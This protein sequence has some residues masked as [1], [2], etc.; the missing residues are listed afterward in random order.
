ME[1]ENRQP[2]LG[3]LV[4]TAAE[5]MEG[6]RTI[7]HPYEPE[8]VE[9]LQTAAAGKIR[10]VA[11]PWYRGRMA[12]AAGVLLVAL[13]ALALFV[14]RMPAGGVAVA[15]VA[16]PWA[17][18]TYTHV[19]VRPGNTEVAVG[20]SLNVVAVFHG[21]LPHDASLRWRTAQ[22]DYWQTIP[23]SPAANG[24]CTNLM[25]NLTNAIVYQV[26]G[27]GA[28]SPEYSVNTFTPPEIKS[29]TTRVEFPAYTKHPAVEQT[30]P[31]LRVVRGSHLAF[32][33][34]VAGD[35]ASA[36]LC[37]S[38]QPPIEL[39]RDADNRW[40]ANLAKP[41]S[42]DY[43]LELIDT[44]GRTGGN[45][46]PYHLVVVPDEPPLV[47]IVDP[48]ADVRA[49]PTDKVPLRVTA[50]DDFAVTGI[51]V[52]YHKLGQPEQSLTCLAT[53]LDEAS[54]GA[55]AAID[56]TPLHLQPYELVA[57]HAEARD[58]NTLDG[59]GTGKSPVYFIEFTTNSEVV[60]S[61]GGGGGG[62]GQKINLLE[63]EKQII[64]ATTAV[65]EEKLREKLPDVASVQRQTQEYAQTFRDNSP[66][67][68]AAP[69]EAR[70]EFDAALKSMGG[71]IIALN[72]VQ[73]EPSLTSEEDALEHLYQAVKYFPELKPCMCNCTGIKIVAQAIEKKKQEDKQQQK[74]E[75]PKLIA[76]AKKAAAAQAQLNGL[77]RR[78]AEEANPSLAKKE[79][80]KPGSKPGSG[81]NGP[82]GENPPPADNPDAPEPPKAD[83]PE[84]Q[85]MAANPSVAQ[86][87]L[88]EQ[89]SEMAAKLRELAGNN[90]QISGPA[91][92]THE[93]RGRKYAEGRKARRW[94]QHARGGQH[95]Q[96]RPIRNRRYHRIAGNP[97]ERPAARLG[98]RRRGISPRVRRQDRRLS[99]RP[100]VSTM[101][102]HRSEH[103]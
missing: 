17:N 76:Q 75:L 33:V 37:L 89:A 68:A 92:A 42:A 74:K 40:T 53:N 52:V 72:M 26:A 2:D 93:R 50:S 86:T 1:L 97:G 66:I 94:R 34:A 36:K 100:L 59:P 22:A 69:P 80:Q 57:Y 43:R 28:T 11:T 90:P 32:H 70:T 45:D 81:N 24:N 58:N 29:L 35:V 49:N 79:G 13:A 67:L 46:T 7:D 25:A 82:T 77:Y 73:R 83:N 20:R 103:D 91:R 64:A 14:W 39:T 9:A 56:L 96:L 98:I 27:G 30:T 44:K 6:K 55:T 4:S 23:L 8:L 38:N 48:Q 60:P 15:R 21:R 85:Q 65:P 95:G 101:T 88:A 16:W 47:D 102:A 61:S 18:V 62:G 84:D 3:C 87:R 78:T 99:A 63:L 5:Y 12:A 41:V 54:A 19:E 10:T 71:A 51:K 31:D